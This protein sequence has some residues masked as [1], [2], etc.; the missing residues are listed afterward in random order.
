MVRRFAIGAVL[1][2]LPIVSFPHTE[3]PAIAGV[4][5]LVENSPWQSNY[6]VFCAALD[7]AVSRKADL[8]QLYEGKRVSWRLRFRGFPTQ[9]RGPGGEYFHVTL[10]FETGRG[11]V[12]QR[13]W[14]ISRQATRRDWDAIKPG[15]WVTV[16]GKITS[17]GVAELQGET[18]AL[19]EIEEVDSPVEFVRG[20]NLSTEDGENS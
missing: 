20:P 6:N 3:G 1:L 14:F 17:A 13:F 8:G 5:D 2:A 19:F 7:K 12:M 15:A 4:T 18:C 11:R 9:W 16:R 10:L